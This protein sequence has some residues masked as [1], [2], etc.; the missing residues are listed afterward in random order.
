HTRE[1]LALLA[2]RGVA[3]VEP[4][5]EA[6][7]GPLAGKTFVITGTLSRSR[8]D[9][10]ADIEAAGGKVTGSV[11]KKT[12]YLVAGDNT[13]KAKLAAAEKHKVEVIDEAGLARLLG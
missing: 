3:P 8:A 11:S 7:G 9:I 13:G 5:A 1:V 12:D 6:K 4:V 2:E 10:A